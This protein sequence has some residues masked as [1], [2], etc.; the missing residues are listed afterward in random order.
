[1]SL[2]RQ[3]RKQQATDLTTWLCCPIAFTD[4]PKWPIAQLSKE[5]QVFLV[6]ET[7]QTVIDIVYVGRH[8]VWLC[9]RRCARLF[10][11]WAFLL[12]RRYLQNWPKNH[13]K[14]QWMSQANLTSEPNTAELLWHIYR[15]LF[16]LAGNYTCRTATNRSS[17]RVHSACILTGF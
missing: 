8:G 9:W 16:S 3:T 11:N 10:G 12:R 13:V 2:K 1:M 4:H 5:V 15:T 7:R 14:L 6:D 17:Y